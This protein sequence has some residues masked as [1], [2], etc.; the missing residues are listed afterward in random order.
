[1]FC[2]DSF[3]SLSPLSVKSL[4]QAPSKWPATVIYSRYQSRKRQSE[5][6]ALRL[7]QDASRPA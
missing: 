1:M 6:A 4:E 2:F 5:R 3:S 7:V